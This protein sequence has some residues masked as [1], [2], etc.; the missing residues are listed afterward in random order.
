MNIYVSEYS[1]PNLFLTSEHLNF[2][3]IHMN[4]IQ[5]SNLFRC[6]IFNW[7]LGLMFAISFSPL[8][9]ISFLVF[10]ILFRQFNL[11]GRSV[12]SLLSSLYFFYIYYCTYYSTRLHYYVLYMFKSFERHF[13][14]FPLLVVSRS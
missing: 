3:Q 5:C 9:V 2:Q 6:A 11:F 8:L 13:L 7:F 14:H 10:F 1:A 12:C 4:Q